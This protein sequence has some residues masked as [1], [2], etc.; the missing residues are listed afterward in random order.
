[1]PGAEPFFRRGA[2]ENA[3]TGVLCLHGLTATPHE[4]RWL[5]EHL[6]TQGYTVLA[7]RIAG[8]GTDYHDLERVTW[9]DWYTSALDA[10]HVLAQNCER[11]FVAGLSMGSLLTLLLAQSVPVVG[12]VGMA[13]PLKFQSRLMPY[14]HHIKRVNRYQDFADTS[15]FPRYLREEQLRLGE[16]NYGR[17]RYDICPMN[18]LAEIYALGNTVRESL[19][20]VNV[21]TC[22]IFSKSDRTVPFENFQIAVDGLRN[23]V[24]ETHVLEKSGHIM[25]M[26]MERETVFSHI[27]AF[28]KSAS[29]L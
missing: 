27:S 14:A 25:T 10:Y 28:I 3:S 18:A 11:V 13:V 6:N 12:I 9:G 2:G 29:P 1:M 8:H 20:Q 5:A 17:V 4:V 24:V 23:A 21:P 26:D 19:P 22:L 16:P 7:P 15:D